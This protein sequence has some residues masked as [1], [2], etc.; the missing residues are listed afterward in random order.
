NIESFQQDIKT[1]LQAANKRYKAAADR[2]Q[3]KPPA[4]LVG[5]L[6]WLDSSNIR[7]T[8]PTKK[9]SEKKFGPFEITAVVSKN[10]FRLKLPSSWL[11]IHPVF[12]V[13]LLSSSIPPFPGK[14]QPPP[15][16]VEV[17][18]HLEWEVSGILDSQQRRGR[19]QYLVEW[20]GYMDDSDRTTWEPASN[21]T[22]CPDLLKTFHL[23]YPDK[24]RP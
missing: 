20:S 17:Q 15:E 13:L 7:L 19:L 5:D 8:R 4:F 1:N 6:V 12:H 10:A 16:P 9:L 23:S 21:L 14:S 24:P 3:L 2:H 18:D 11:R 22:N